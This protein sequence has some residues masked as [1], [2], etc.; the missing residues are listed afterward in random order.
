MM[1]FLIALRRIATRPALPGR[2]L[3]WPGSSS[4]YEGSQRQARY[5]SDHSAAVGSSSPYEGSQRLSVA[6]AA[7]ADPDEGSSSPYEGSQPMAGDRIVMGRGT[8]FLI[9]LRGIATLHRPPHPPGPWHRF[10]IALRGIATTWPGSTP[11]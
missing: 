8:R 4:P 7:D 1:G 2:R 6:A 9:A 5:G 11:G 3:R 10:L